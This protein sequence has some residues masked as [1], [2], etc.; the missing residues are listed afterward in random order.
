MDYYNKDIKQVFKD[1][2]SSI[3][4]LSKEEV[5]KVHYWEGTWTKLYSV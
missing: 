2:S 4:G 5:F 1:L 3:E